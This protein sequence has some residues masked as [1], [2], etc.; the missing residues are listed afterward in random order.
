MSCEQCANA[1]WPEACEFLCSIGVT[2]PPPTLFLPRDLPIPP[3]D[4]LLAEK[5][6]RLEDELQISPGQPQP[7]TVFEIVEVLRRTGIHNPALWLTLSIPRL[8]SNTDAAHTRLLG[9]ALQS[10]ARL[11]D[12][13]N[14]AEEAE[15]AFALAGHMYTLVGQILR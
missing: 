15:S 2:Q 12:A 8:V 3:A 13:L 10:Q 9:Q 5:L 6:Q 1:Y 4:K 11:L 7:T 14:R